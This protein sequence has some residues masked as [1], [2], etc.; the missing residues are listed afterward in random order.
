MRRLKGVLVAALALVPAMAAAQHSMENPKH[1]LG[2]DL[3]IMYSKPKG[4]DG[5]FSI[6]TPV[7]V[8]IGFVSGGKLE[9]EPR[10]TFNYASGGGDNAYVFTPDINLLFGLSADGNRKG[11]YFTAGAGVDLTH[12]SIG[13]VSASTSQ[14]NFNGGIGTRVPYESGAFRLEAFARY[15]LK[16]TSKGLP[17]TLDIGAR[18]GLSLWH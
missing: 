16:N 5:V 14:F 11:P 8:R 1:E 15:L 2:V 10:F 9:V 12:V 17:N 3:G 13:G 4:G 6:G 18:I 7:D